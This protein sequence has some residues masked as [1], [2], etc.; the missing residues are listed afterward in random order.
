MYFWAQGKYVT[1]GTKPSILPVS[2]GLLEIEPAA[3]VSSTSQKV[4]P[5]FPSKTKKC[6]LLVKR[7]S[8]T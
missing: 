1:I 8:Y 2:L 7:K 3:Y 4:S 6:P 5:K